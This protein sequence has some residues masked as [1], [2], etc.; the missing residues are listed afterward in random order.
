MSVTSGGT[1]LK[2]FRMGGRSSGL[3]GA[4]GMVIVL[5]AFHSPFSWYQVQIE[6]DRSVVLV[7]TPTKP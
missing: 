7:T 4:A 3:A 1:A 2:L 5:R 6:L